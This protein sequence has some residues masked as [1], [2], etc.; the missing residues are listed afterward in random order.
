MAMN[1]LCKLKET[2]K[3]ELKLKQQ[4]LPRTRRMKKMVML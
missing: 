1:G 4:V 2:I 3:K